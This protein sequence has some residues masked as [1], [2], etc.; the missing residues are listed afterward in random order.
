[1]AA[2][3]RI[4]IAVGA[5]SVRE[6]RH[7]DE[8]ERLRPEWNRLLQANR[9]LGLF[10]TP[11]W[12]RPWW[13]AYGSGRELRVLVMKGDAGVV[14]IV[15]MYIER[16]RPL[17]PISIR[18]LRL[19]G[20][21]SGDSDDLDITVQPGYEEAVVDSILAW[22]R[23]SDWDVCELNCVSPRSSVLPLLRE[24]IAKAQWKYTVS[25]KAM[26]AVPL[27]ATW[28]E[29][30]KQ[31]SSKERGK[32]GNRYRHLLNAYK[33]NFYRCERMEELPGA[34]ETLFALHQKR[35]ELKGLP[36]AF[37]SADRRLFYYNMAAALLAKDQLELWVLQLN[38]E[39][40][41]A[42]I[43]LRYGARVCALQEGFD[44]G[45]GSDSVGYV[46]RAYVLRYC[47]EHGVREYDFLAGDQDSKQRWGTLSGNYTNLHFA[48]PGS[49]GDAH[50]TLAKKARFVKDWLRDHVSEKTFERAQRSRI[51]RRLLGAE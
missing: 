6:I 28:E 4:P 13:H 20:D 46:L 39:P 15:P 12:L 47:I 16:A 38:G 2:N 42:Q 27:P 37:S 10:A 29:Y 14:A 23:T 50:I 48:K 36:G 30:L 45:Y 22:A 44:P 41:A 49:M 1:M 24:R 3:V 5:L 8:M 34:L 26:V 31:L 9:A 18:R 7:W 33:T 32:V 40:A 11:E 17:L 35:W 25:E 43:G 19:I 51:A 21:G